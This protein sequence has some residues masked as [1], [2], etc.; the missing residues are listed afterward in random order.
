MP[1]RREKVRARAGDCCEYCQLPQSLSVLP[2]GLDHIR[3]RKHVGPTTLENLCLACAHCNA[4]KGPNVA[5]Y[6]PVSGALT[7]LFNPRTQIWS[8]HFEWRGALLR[9]KTSAGRVTVELLGINRAERAE[10]RRLLRLAGAWKPNT[11]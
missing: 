4:A 7:P 11:A 3:A 6:D 2:H 10:H 8:E 1:S 5:G 9:G